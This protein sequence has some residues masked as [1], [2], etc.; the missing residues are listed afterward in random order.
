[1]VEHWMECAGLKAVGIIIPLYHSKWD[2]LDPGV[3]C[4]IKVRSL[5]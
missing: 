5:D 3:D 1:M 2:A 4:C